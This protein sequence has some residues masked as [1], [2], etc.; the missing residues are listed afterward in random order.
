M[1]ELY[2]RSFKLPCTVQVTQA[3]PLPCLAVRM[4]ASPLSSV[5]DHVI[6]LRPP[7]PNLRNAACPQAES[8][9]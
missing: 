1:R 6:T 4:R 7:H 8:M 5:R 3:R 2:P 9:N